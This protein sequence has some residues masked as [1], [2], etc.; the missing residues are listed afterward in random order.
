MLEDPSKNTFHSPE[1]GRSLILFPMGLYT[2]IAENRGDL[3]IC[4]SGN[5]VEQELR[6]TTSQRSYNLSIIISAQY[7]QREAECINLVTLLAPFHALPFLEESVLREILKEQP[8][9]IDSQIFIY[10]ETEKVN[11]TI[12]CKLVFSNSDFKIVIRNVNG[13]L[14]L[15]CSPSQPLRIRIPQIQTCE[16]VTNEIL[17]QITSQLDPELQLKV[18]F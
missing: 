14:E 1:E 18:I 2:Q 12:V 7:T 13:V 5:E 9:V 16:I 8:L 17:R 11:A 6:L 10:P 15:T 3:P 4:Q